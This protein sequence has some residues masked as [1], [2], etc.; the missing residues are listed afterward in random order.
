MPFM[1]LFHVLLVPWCC[2]RSLARS[3]GDADTV[4]M[5]MSYQ[6]R[7]KVRRRILLGEEGS[8]DVRRDENTVVSN[9]EQFL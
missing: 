9:A 6:Q 1:Q 4:I 8:Y 3:A 2:G 5:G 7:F